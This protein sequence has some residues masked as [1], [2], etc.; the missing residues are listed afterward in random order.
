MASLQISPLWGEYPGKPN[1]LVCKA[2]R[3]F[4]WVT[5]WGTGCWYVCRLI[6]S[7][8]I[9]AEWVEFP[10]CL[11]TITVSWSYWDTVDQYSWTELGFED[12]AERSEIDRL[13]NR[14]QPQDPCQRDNW[15]LACYAQYIVSSCLAGRI[16]NL[17]L[18]HRYHSVN[19]CSITPCL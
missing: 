5:S 4:S 2:R 10:S 19:F 15:W 1:S 9:T 14:C 16:S 17:S 13:H 7:S 11:V 6:E 3:N 18:T 8:F 12:P